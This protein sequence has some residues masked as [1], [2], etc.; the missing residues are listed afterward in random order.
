MSSAAPLTATTD[1]TFLGWPCVG[2]QKPHLQL[3]ISRRTGWYSSRW[4][5]KSS[6]FYALSLEPHFE[7]RPT[8]KEENHSSDASLWKYAFLSLGEFLVH[9]RAASKPHLWEIC[10][11]NTNSPT[12]KAASFCQLQGVCSPRPLSSSSCC[13]QGHP[14]V[15][16][17][18]SAGRAGSSP[19][20]SPSGH[21][22]PG[23]PRL[24]QAA[25]RGGFFQTLT[26][27]F[28]LITEFTYIEKNK[29]RSSLLSVYLRPKIVIKINQMGVLKK[30]KKSHLSVI[31]QERN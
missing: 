8:G 28:K 1:R 17:G 6:F 10:L 7:Y 25:L 29:N 12:T 4:Q 26:F 22:K 9:V 18:S 19:S 31:K 14:A 13:S 23:T 2:I 11:H 30:K 21:C 5:I 24:C 27:K 15:Q 20:T 16:P 3:G